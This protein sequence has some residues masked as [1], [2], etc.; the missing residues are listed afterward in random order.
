MS[1]PP[2]GRRWV[3]FFAILVLLAGAG[4]TIPIVYNLRQQLTPDQLDGA[5]ARW[6][7]HGPRS[8]NFR[9]VVKRSQSE[10]E[11]YYAEVRGGRVVR[12]SVNGRPLPPE[13]RHYHDMEHRFS[14]IRGFLNE[15]TKTGKP[16]VF[17][18]AQFDAKDGRL[19]RYVRSVTSTR[20]R[21]EIDVQELTPVAPG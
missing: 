16:R 11:T 14:D 15:D 19:I 20:T 13:N 9:Y 4:V 2:Q 21:V 8:Y 7:E 17:V 18:T 1:I 6:R 10:P 3:W 5:V 12:A